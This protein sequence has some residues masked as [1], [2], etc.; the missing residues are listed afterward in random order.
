M[1]DHPTPIE[2][3][4]HTADPVPFLLWGKSIEPDGTGRFTESEARGTGVFIDE[5][6]KI[7]GKLVGK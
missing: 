7:M 2:L 6:F 4:T 3:R 1:P 5:G